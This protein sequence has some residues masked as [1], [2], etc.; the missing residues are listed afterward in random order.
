MAAIMLA[1]WF[2][3]SR[4][5]FPGYEAMLPTLGAVAL[6]YA[7]PGEEGLLGRLLGSRPMQYFG[8]ISYSLYLWHWPI[9]VFYPL[10]TGR[11]VATFQ[12]GM[13]V[14]VVS[15]IAA[16]LS[17][18]LVEERFRHGRKGESLRPYMIGAGLTATL[19]LSAGTL[20]A[21]G[22]REAK[23]QI[24]SLGASGLAR[25][26]A[27]APYRLP[28]SCFAI[29]AARARQAPWSS[30]AIRMPCTGYPRWSSWPSRSSYASLDSQRVVAPSRP[31]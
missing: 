8:D 29:T 15:V 4:L 21:A 26:A 19:A 6:L 20:L 23:A 30:W 16:H 10:V 9:V 27:S 22:D 18:Q 3:S 17:K 1:C 5:P 14:A 25:L 31:H 2:Y 24:A 28:N 13:A 7:R 11:E 12:D